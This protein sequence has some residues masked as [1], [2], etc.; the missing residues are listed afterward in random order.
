MKALTLVM[1]K[2]NQKKLDGKVLGS[3]IIS[4]YE[5]LKKQN[6]L[7]DNDPDNVDKGEIDNL[8]NSFVTL[9]IDP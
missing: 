1:T 6:M 8:A 2:Y 4:F 9:A 5:V 3:T 7:I